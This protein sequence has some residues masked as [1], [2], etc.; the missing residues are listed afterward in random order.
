VPV[1]LSNP[2]LIEL[3]AEL[4]ELG[5]D[6]TYADGEVLFRSGDEVD[7]VYL[8]ADGRVSLWLSCERQ[9]PRLFEEAHAGTL[10]GLSE[11]LS[12]DCYKLTARAT[13]EVHAAYVRR[14]ELLDYLRKHPA[15]CMHVVR[16]LSDDLNLLYGKYCSMEDDKRKSRK[17]PT[18]EPAKAHAA[19]RVH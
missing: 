8:V 15:C 9:S 1:D 3:C 16:L 13:G 18:P 6:R 19:R 11:V 4:R 14:D 7:G 5:S 17:R 10:L 2:L 12:G